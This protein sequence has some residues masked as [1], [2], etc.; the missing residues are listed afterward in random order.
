MRVFGILALIFTLAQAA[1]A[2][3]TRL[4]RLDTGEDSRGWTAVGRL[5][6]DGRGFCTGALIAPDLV[7][8]AAHCMFDAHTRDRLDPARIE[9]RAGWR[10]GRAEAYRAVRRAVV[11]P[12]FVFE[13]VNGATRVRHDLALLELARPI[14]DTRI[15]P[16]ATGARPRKGDEV[17]VVSYA[18]DRAEAPSLQKVCRVMARNRGVLVLSCNVDFGSSG[19]PV[20]AIRDGAAEIVSVVSAKSDWQGTPVALS[21]DLVA[22][23]ATLR[24]ELAAGGGTL[25]PPAPA[26]NAVRVGTRHNTGAK[27]VKP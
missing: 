25:T 4:Q 15:V 26:L 7:L 18:H 11:H 8:T 21:T 6:L 19:A 3:D 2:E 17:G 27:F 20:F 24:A 5:D 12:S 23:L 22:P 14:R 9:F 1:W 13:G 16:F 10:N